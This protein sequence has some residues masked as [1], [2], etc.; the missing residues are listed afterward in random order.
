[1]ALST[2]V[3]VSGINNLSDA[4]YC[5]G[6][7][8]DSLGFNLNPEDDHY[9]DADTFKEIT[10]WVAG[11]KLVGEFGNLE[12]EKI[13]E[14]TH[15]YELN[16]IK[17]SDPHVVAALKPIGLPIIL[18]IDVDIN[19]GGL[20]SMLSTFKNSVVYFLLESK[21][22]EISKNNL[23]Q[24]Q[25]LAEEFPILLGLG[26]NAATVADLLTSSAL[27]G[28]SLQGGNEIKPGYKDFDE[29]ADILELLETD[30]SY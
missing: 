23:N 19:F 18:G 20:S 29:L 6:M 22:E 17:V 14:T 9:I 16:F 13:I 30:E 5:A 26:I 21:S 4:R 25:K 11:V 7:G 12:A 15:E 3:Y 10:N 1:M 8:V 27:S 2:Y 28:I 24:L